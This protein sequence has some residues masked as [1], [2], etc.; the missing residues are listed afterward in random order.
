MLKAVSAGS[1]SGWG[2]PSAALPGGSVQQVPLGT[3]AHRHRSA[4]P[5]SERSHRSDQS[6]GALRP[7]V[8]KR[9]AGVGSQVSLKGGKD[10]LRGELRMRSPQFSTA[11]AARGAPRGLGPPAG[12]SPRGARIDAAGQC[13]SRIGA[14]IDAYAVAGRVSTLEARKQLGRGVCGVDG[15]VLAHSR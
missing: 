7:R 4:H 1:E 5:G 9:G 11:W 3:V 10:E 6:A 13:A 12:L 2:D 8:G 14:R 15:A